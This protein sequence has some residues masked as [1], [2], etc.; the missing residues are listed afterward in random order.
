[1]SSI[2]VRVPSMKRDRFR[3]LEEATHHSLPIVEFVSLNRVEKFEGDW[4]RNVDLGISSSYKRRN[5]ARD[6]EEE[7][8]TVTLEML[9]MFFTYLGIFP[10]ETPLAED[11]NDTLRE[12][13]R[14]AKRICERAEEDRPGP[15]MMLD[16]Q[17]HTAEDSKRITELCAAL[18]PKE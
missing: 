1:M 15:L 2:F 7:E 12:I 16:L 17:H 14:I 3:E 6:W 11:L 13:E 9:D 4:V 5:V 18:F 10:R 8:V